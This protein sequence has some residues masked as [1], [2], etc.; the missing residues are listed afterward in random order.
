M[1]PHFAR[2]L[3]LAMLLAAPLAATTAAGVTPDVPG[4]VLREL[5]ER[6]G[7]PRGE[8]GEIPLGAP[9]SRLDLAAVEAPAPAGHD[10]GPKSTRLASRASR[11]PLA[12]RATG[13]GGMA[14]AARATVA[15][16]HLHCVYRL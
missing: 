12:P 13:R 6:A 1:R 4:D 2:L 10:A 7:P 9:V 15:L 16:R 8:T 14:A 3:A 11:T 5:V